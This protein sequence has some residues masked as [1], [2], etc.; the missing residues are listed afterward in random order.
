MV[1]GCGGGVWGGGGVGGTFARHIGDVRTGWNGE[2]KVDAYNHVTGLF[3]VA[4]WARSLAKVEF[5]VG[6][7][8][9]PGREDGR[10]LGLCQGAVGNQKAV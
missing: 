10:G 2:V 9:Y 5:G 8:D 7:V 6:R 1:G 3:A 4:T